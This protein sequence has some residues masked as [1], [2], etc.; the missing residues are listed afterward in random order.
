MTRDLLFIHVY[1][2]RAEDTPFGGIV[3]IEIE[4]EAEPALVAER[5]A[6]S[7]VQRESSI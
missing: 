5:L 2:E 3:T 7:I 6:L 4:G 1:L